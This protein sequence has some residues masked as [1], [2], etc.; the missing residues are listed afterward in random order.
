MNNAIRVRWMKKTAHKPDRFLVTSP[1][2]SRME[3]SD[4]EAKHS[5][6]GGYSNEYECRFN[7]AAMKFAEKQKWSTRLVGG[8][9]GIGDYVFVEQKN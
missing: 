5:H 6:N 3:V 2:M 1:G 4:E 7:Y 9:F 8:R